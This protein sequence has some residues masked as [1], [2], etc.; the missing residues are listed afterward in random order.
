MGS[1]VGFTAALVRNSDDSELGREM[2][3]KAQLGTV[4]M[5]QPHYRGRISHRS[6]ADNSGFQRLFSWPLFFFSFLPKSWQKVDFLHL[7]LRCVEPWYAE[8][9]LP[10][11][12]SFRYCIA[13][14][15]TECR[16]E[17]GTARKS[18]GRAVI[19]KSTG[20]AEL[21]VWGS[22]LMARL[23]GKWCFCWTA[24]QGLLKILWCFYRTLQLPSGPFVLVRVGLL[25]LVQ[26]CWVIEMRRRN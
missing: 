3:S 15:K 25:P 13:K 20:G 11:R 10:W 24:E 6:S 2:L 8:P 23:K 16:E 19:P 22:Y 7:L 5:T 14:C 12:K 9:A 1:G 17:E 4:I 21:R 26:N 18:R